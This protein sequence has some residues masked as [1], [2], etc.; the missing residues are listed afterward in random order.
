MGTRGFITFVIN[1]TEKTTYNHWDSYPSGLGETVLSWLKDAELDEARR[2]AAELVMVDG[3][4]PPTS[5]QIER[6]RPHTDLSVSRQSADDWYCLLRGTQGDPAAILAAGFSVDASGF[7][8]DSL[9]A[10]WGY[11]VDFDTQTFE[12]Y[13]GFQWEPHTLGRFAHLAPVPNNIGTTYYPVARV[14]SWPLTDLPASLCA[15]QD[16]AVTA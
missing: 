15:D 2:L 4:T 13:E 12:L 5:E 6:L 9:Y 11:V 10:E 16:E 14:A 7:P 1:G 8:A 3:N